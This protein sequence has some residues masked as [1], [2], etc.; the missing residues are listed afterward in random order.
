MTYSSRSTTV[1]SDEEAGFSSG[2]RR[3]FRYVGRRLTLVA[4]FFAAHGTVQ[5]ADRLVTTLEDQN[6][7]PAGAVISLREAIRDASAGDKVIFEPTLFSAPGAIVE[8]QSELVVDKAVMVDGGSLADGVPVSGGG[9]TR[10]FRVTASG[11]LTLR[12]LTL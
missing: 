3:V 2:F 4:S 12:G 5:A 1:A 9:I 6:D 7:V 11:D 10:L 8:L